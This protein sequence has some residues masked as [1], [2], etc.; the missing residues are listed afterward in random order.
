MKVRCVIAFKLAE[1][2]VELQSRGFTGVSGIIDQITGKTVTMG[3]AFSGLTSI[4]PGVGL[5]LGA[6]GTGVSVAGMVK[7]AAAAEMTAVGFQTMMGS[8]SEAKKVMEDLSNFAATTPLGSDELN[9]AARSLLAFNTPAEELIP[10]L[11]AI[12]DISTGI[13]APIGEIAE[14]FGKNRVQFQL[15]MQDIHQL[16]GRGIP[17]FQELAKQFGVN[18][19]EIRNLVSSGKVNFTHLEQAFKSMTSEGGIFYNMMGAG[20][21]TLSGKWSNLQDNAD[22]AFRDIG[23]GII[24]AFDLKGILDG[25]I[26]FTDGFR[27]A[28]QPIIADVVPSIRHLMESLSGSFGFAWEQMTGATGTGVD[29]VISGLREIGGWAI[30]LID[31][32]SFVIDNWGLLWGIAY[33]NAALTFTNIIERVKTWGINVSEIASWAGNNFWDIMSTATDAVLTIFINLGTNIRMVWKEIIDYIWSMGDDPIK[34]NFTPMLDGFKSTI[35]EMPQLT[36]AAIQ[37]TT[38]ELDRL[39]TSLAENALKSGF[40]LNRPAPPS[41]AEAAIEATKKAN[42]VAVGNSAASKGGGFVGIAELAR[43]VQ[44]SALSKSDKFAQTTAE[45]TAAMATAMTTGKGVKVQAVPLDARKGP[46][47][48]S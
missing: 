47:F 34:F 31:T 3:S 24:Q 4:L 16:T 35:R 17:M 41:F 15:Q 7:S 30:D 6:I 11:Q 13:Q 29:F 27:T 36:E 43:G 8:A 32:T 19:S 21:E 42:N 48:A 1:A 12:G 20:A 10:T 23:T 26:E 46:S 37:T 45:A 38:A 25:T 33:E 14:I 2:Y 40:G 22:M 5:A 9:R 28:I 18:E 44:S 39:N